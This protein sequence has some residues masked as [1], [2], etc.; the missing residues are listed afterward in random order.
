MKTIILTLMICL[1]LLLTLASCDGAKTPAESPVT[2]A[3]TLHQTQESTAEEA[4][5]AEPYNWNLTTD[6][7]TIEE[8]DGT[9][10]IT[11]KEEYA[12]S[13]EQKQACHLIEVTFDSMDAMVNAFRSNTLTASQEVILQASFPTSEK[14]IALW[15]ADGLYDALTPEDVRVRSLYLHG[16]TYGFGLDGGDM[17]ARGFISYMTEEQWLS[18][19]DRMYIWHDTARVLSREQS[20]YDGAPCE[21]VIYKKSSAKYKAI[22]V[23]T[24]ENGKKVYIVMRYLLEVTDPAQTESATSDTVPTDTLIF[25]EDN[26]VFYE[27]DLYEMKQSPSYAWLSAFGLTPYTPTANGNTDTE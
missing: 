18:S 23:E 10:Y 6:R 17:C 26:G 5:T 20:T 24:E 3:P 9:C 1:T 4:E 16:S 7:Y 11:F 21:T 2:E 19:K 8:I 13:E 22:Y 15:T 12:I 25:C 14:G 27:I